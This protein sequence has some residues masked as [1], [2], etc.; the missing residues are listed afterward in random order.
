MTAQK[1]A[2]NI[3]LIITAPCSQGQEDQEWVYQHDSGH[4][5]SNDG[6][7]LQANGSKIRAQPCAGSLA[8]QQWDFDHTT[9]LLHGR[10][11]FYCVDA[12][13][14]DPT[15]R[16]QPCSFVTTA[17][18]QWMFGNETGEHSLYCWASMHPGGSD[19]ELL[20]L[21][22]RRN[23]GIF[24]CNSHEIFSL[25]GALVQGIPTTGLRGDL[26]PPCEADSGSVACKGA[27]YEAAWKHI[28]KAGWYTGFEW[29]VRVH[30]DAVFIPAR[31]S[32]SLRR[33]T[34]RPGG[35]A[36]YLTGSQR[37][38]QEVGPIE[39]LSRQA[40]DHLRSH[41]DKCLGTGQKALTYCMFSQLG[42]KA[43]FIPELLRS[44]YRDGSDECRGG[45]VTFHAYKAANSLEACYKEA[46]HA[47]SAP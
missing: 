38:S 34:R 37:E 1:P 36:V 28:F 17:R 40:V 8:G 42:V 32:W 39:V 30:A 41:A 18:Q 11:G 29:T 16:V 43:S 5:R 35:R 3:S 26:A 4:L 25:P 14:D 2:A 19:A 7:C 12:S 9:G 23:W 33:A 10:Q 47:S 44:N 6:L 13:N 22:H 24:T 46:I 45:V 15:V 31:L 20:S 21:Q 27:F